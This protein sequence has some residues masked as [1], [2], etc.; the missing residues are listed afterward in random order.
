MSAN[1]SLRFTLASVAALL[2]LSGCSA[3]AQ[4]GNPEA[5]KVVRSGSFLPSRIRTVVACVTD[6]FT[7]VT[8]PGQAFDLRQSRQ[9]NGYRIDLY[10]VNSA[11]LL[12]SAELLDNG[13]GE[14]RESFKASMTSLAGEYAAF[15]ACLK[16]SP[17][18]GA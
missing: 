13:T 11:V 1:C 17:Q 15:D 8:H 9:A 14:L 6:G 7:V 5:F 10:V 3:P 12:L 2:A 4:V 16:A 18:P